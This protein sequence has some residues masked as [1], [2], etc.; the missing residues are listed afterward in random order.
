MKKTQ[1]WIWS[2]LALLLITGALIGGRT[3]SGKQSRPAFGDHALKVGG[4]W[5]SPQ[6]FHEE[7]NRF[8]LRYRTHAAM[9]RKTDEERMDLVLEEIINRVVIA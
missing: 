7:Q 5:V 4:Q 8:Y 2:G 1:G 6:I 9:L 3:V